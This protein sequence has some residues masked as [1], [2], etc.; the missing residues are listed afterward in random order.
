MI[1][2]DLVKVDGFEWDEGN[3][4]KNEIKHKVFYKECEEIFFDKPLYLRDIKHSKTEA[5]FYAFGETNIK[6]LLTIT[7]TIRSQKI[8]VISARKQD[9]KEKKFYLMNITNYQK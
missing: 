4:K 1:S 6:R 9:K 3:I 2:L 5:R 8:R 7:F